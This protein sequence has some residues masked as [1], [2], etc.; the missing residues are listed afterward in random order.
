M[1]N[2]YLSTGNA[3]YRQGGEGLTWLECSS[4][5]DR[6][7]LIDQQLLALHSLTW[8]DRPPT[9]KGE[10]GASL[11]N[12]VATLHL[13]NSWRTVPPRKFPTPQPFPG[14]A[15]VALPDRSMVLRKFQRKVRKTDRVARCNEVAG[16]PPT[17]SGDT[18]RVERPVTPDHLPCDAVSTGAWVRTCRRQW[19]PTTATTMTITP[20]PQTPWTD[21]TTGNHYI[22][23][24]YPSQSSPSPLPSHNHNHPITT[25]VM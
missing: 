19:S 20:L 10:G 9:H 7:R 22:P 18:V 5:D 2:P 17:G 24:R 6:H 11:G 21:N 4:G 25:S 14:A 15:P 13:L 16:G 3:R 1:E 8:G 23:L 12:S